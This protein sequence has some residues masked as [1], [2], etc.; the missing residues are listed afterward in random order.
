MMS[1][2]FICV[3]IKL[4][5]FSSEFIVLSISTLI[6]RQVKVN[7]VLGSMIPDVFFTKVS[8][9]ALLQFVKI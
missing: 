6:I 4:F 1:P 3:N 8:V 7:W 9:I 5:H 2:L